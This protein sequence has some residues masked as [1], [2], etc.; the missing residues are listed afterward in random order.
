M[1]KAMTLMALLCF[2]VPA[3]AQETPA[4]GWFVVTGTNLMPGQPKCAAGI[5]QA[6]RLWNA[7]AIGQ[8]LVVVPEQKS[9]PYASADDAEKALAGAGWSKD[10][11]GRWQATSGCEEASARP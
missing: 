10:A 9:G 7:Y 4:P 2:P 11:S 1:H 3:P 6:N 5:V 8:A